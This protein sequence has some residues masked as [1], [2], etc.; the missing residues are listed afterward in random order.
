MFLVM[1]LVLVFFAIMTHGEHWDRDAGDIPAYFILLVSFYA[2]C[3][4]VTFF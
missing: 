2:L 4:L 3:G 1:T